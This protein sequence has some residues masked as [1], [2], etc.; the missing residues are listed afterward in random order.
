MSV[1]FTQNITA[2][3]DTAGGPQSSAAFT[4][5]VGNAI[6]VAMAD[7]TNNGRTLVYSGSV[8]TP[9]AREV[10]QDTTNG[11]TLGLAQILPALGGSQTLTVNSSPTGDEVSGYAIE[12]GGVG[13]IVVNSN[14]PIIGSTTPAGDAT[15]VPPGCTL[16]G[17]LIQ[18]HF[19]TGSAAGAA[20]GGITN[21]DRQTGFNS[22]VFAISEWANTG[23]S[24]ATVTPNW[25]AVS[26]N[27]VVLQA[28]LLNNIPPGS[29]YT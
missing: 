21:T 25:T 11:N 6:L 29:I 18:T 26:S 28:L 10:V 14:G 7:V 24:N 9:L 16:V 8:N 12:Y 17:I 2:W 20:S 19:V 3:G 4:P 13:S 1:T 23:S 22:T 27:Y 15:V 5:T